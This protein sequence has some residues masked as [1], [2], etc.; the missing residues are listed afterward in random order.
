[1]G[2]LKSY[3]FSD[4]LN[5]LIPQM[6][7]PT[8]SDLLPG[9]EV[10]ITVANSVVTHIE[11]IK[12]QKQAAVSGTVM[13]VSTDK[14]IVTIQ[15]TDQQLKAFSVSDS[16]Q[17]TISGNA[18]AQLSGI[19]VNDRVDLTVEEGVV[20]AIKVNDRNAQTIVTGTIAAIDTTNRIITLNTDSDGL[21]AFEVDSNA[22]FVINDSTTTILSN[23]KKDMKVEIQMVNN[24]VIYLEFKNTVEGTVE[25]LDSNRR[26]ITI[27]NGSASQTYILDSYVDVDIDRNSSANLSDV[28]R[29][30]FVSIRI[31]DNV[32]TKINVRRIYNYEVIDVLASNNELRVRDS[33]NNKRYLSFDNI[34]KV[35]MPGIDH[36][37]V[38]DFTAGDVI[39]ATFMGTKLDIVEATEVNRGKVT[40]VDNF[41]NTVTIQLFDG[42]AKVYN[43]NVESE[44]VNGTQT[45]SQIN[46]LMNGDRVEI[47]EKTD[48]GLEFS[49]MTKVSTKFQSYTNDGNKIYVAKDPISWRNYVISAKIYVHYGT[50]SLALRNL[51]KDDQIDLYLLDDIVYEIEKK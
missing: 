29:N 36:P 14:R 18:A 28:Y 20:T 7:F 48:G 34:V 4:Q 32:V 23:V 51:A 16:A 8:I 41:N 15:T 30:N 33:D 40:S 50:S 12:A 25:S 5:I 38:E 44:V 49:V 2:K 19:Q 27:D 45:N 46:A 6:R 13:V 9:D 3:Q 17:I 31:E 24:K 26:V 47:R 10:K 21:K 43:F 39:K 35:I 11:L 37:D 1:V 22:Q 42:T